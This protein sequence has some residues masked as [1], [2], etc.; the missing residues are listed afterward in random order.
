MGILA[1]GLRPSRRGLL[2]AG[3]VTAGVVVA[4]LALGSIV[5]PGLVRRAAVERLQAMVTVPVG[6]DRV[7]LNLFTGHARATGIVIGGAAGTPAILRIPAL[8]VGVSYRALLGGQ[9]RV[10]YLVAHGPAVFVERTGPESVNVIQILKP[11][12]GGEPAAVTVDRL[13]IAGGAVTFV[14]RTQFPPFE[15]TFTSIHLVAGRVSTRPDLKL[16]PTS[17]ELGLRIGQGALVIGGA[18]V[19]FGSPGGVELTARMERLDPGL[20]RG[21]LPLRA[22]VDLRGSWVSGEVRYALAYRGNRTTT[23][24]LAAHVETGPIRFLPPDGDVPLVGLDGLAG[25]DVT[26]DF[27]QNH[28]RLGDVVVRG[29]RVA[30]ERRPDGT[31]DLTS[32]LDP[33]PP[34]AAAA[35]GPLETRQA[36]PPAEP[37]PPFTLV[38]ARARVEN[39]DV[40]FTDRTLEP[41]AVTA[42]RSVD[43]ALRD[44]GIGPGTPAGAVEGAAALVQGGRVRLA[45]VVDAGAGAARLAVTLRGLPLARARPYLDAVLPTAETRR[46]TLDGQLDVRL[47]RRDAGPA[48]EV[49]G[50]LD[51]RDVAL[52]VRGAGEPALEARGLTVRLTRLALRPS[53]AAEIDRVRLTGAT[54][55]I[56]RDREGQVALARLWA[57]SGAGR[58]PAARTAAASPGPAVSVRAIEIADGRVRFADAGTR[59]A[60]ETDLTGLRVSLERVPGDGA[61]MRLR[62]SGELAPSAPVELSGWVAPLATP[63]RAHVEVALRDYELARLSPY[64][65]R[66]VSHRVSRGR[67]S[68]RTVLDYEGGRFTAQNRIAIRDL[69]VGEEVDPAFRDGL[70]VPLELAVALLEDAD[71]EIE[72]DLPVSG[73]PEGLRYH[74]GSLIGTAVR[75]A[76]VKTVAAPF[77]LFGSL[78]T[79]GDRVGEVRIDPVEFRGGSLEPDDAA[80]ERLARVIEF[81]ASHR[82]VRLEIRGVAVTAESEALKR[83]RL[84]ARL[85]EPAG[86]AGDTPLEAAYHEA[87]GPLARTAPT[88]D[89]MRRFV[90]DRLEVGRED[91]LALSTGR[92]RTI[93]ETLVRRGVDRDRLSVVTGGAGAVADTGLGRVEFTLRHRA[94][95]QGPT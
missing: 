46:G 35:G 82:R 4:I 81:L 2:L 84:R 80:S 15:R 67:A 6:I 7:R 41:A 25:R 27:L 31:L 56:T 95:G 33:A 57:G 18:A 3:A 55:R 39:G 89:E 53:V 49:G 23:N 91:L 21:Y 58:P 17:F 48:I 20:L 28:L 75:N 66:Y 86:A 69:E 83:E 22:R 76:L 32:L 61:R 38:I 92:A 19:P 85:K 40:A 1:R 65:V 16:T 43:L 93:Q 68:A 26:M 37:R 5:L 44:V 24:R 64:T 72:L 13:E 54:V 62:G 90:L 47:A 77:R 52:G 63:V 59:P 74:L 8:D 11:R 87:G 71:G 10:T 88:V 45:G 30:L 42:L 29:P 73:G 78:L 60:F 51:A 36:A 79:V 12:A 34:P 14:D 94:P 70:G 50:T 9:A